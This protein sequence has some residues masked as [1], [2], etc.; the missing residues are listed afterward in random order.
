MVAKLLKHE[1]IAL[2]RV[3]LPAAIAVI[4]FALLS[5]LTAYIPTQ[6]GMITSTF[7]LLGFVMSSC[8]IVVLA[9]VWCVKRFYDSMF[10]RQG[11]LTLALPVKPAHL[12]FAKVF[13]SVV[14][15]LFSFVAILLAWELFGLLHGVEI[16]GTAVIEIVKVLDQVNAWLIVYALFVGLVTSVCS[17]LFM[18]ACVAAGQLTTKNR[19]LVSIGVYIGGGWIIGLIVNLFTLI[20]MLSMNENQSIAYY[21]PWV[22]LSINLLIYLGVG[23]GSVFFVRYILKSRINLIA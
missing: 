23:I 1:F 9:Y 11:Y 18:F 10:S 13:T 3:L 6:S 5:A 4:A 12:I 7:M 22:V 14:A 2:G 19:A 20:P 8:A 16:V 21:W 17:L 15:I